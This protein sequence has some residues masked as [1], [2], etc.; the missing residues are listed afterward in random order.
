MNGSRCSY[1]RAVLTLTFKLRAHD[2]G[3]TSRSRSLSS[4]R[5]N[6]RRWSEQ[7]PLVLSSIHRVSRASGAIQWIPLSR[8]PHLG[9]L[10]SEKKKKKEKCLWPQAGARR[11]TQ[12][13]AFSTSGGSVPRSVIPA[14]SFAK[15]TADRDVV[16]VITR[17]SSISSGLI[18]YR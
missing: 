5:D 7:R 1:V 14:D 16:S 11:G 13:K 8:V 12:E 4:I 9:A 15:C 10:C 3:T 2:K 6:Y 18:D 17:N